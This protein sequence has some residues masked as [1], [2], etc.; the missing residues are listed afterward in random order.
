MV[1]RLVGR[2]AQISACALL[3]A[4]A[5]PALAAPV[6]YNLDYSGAGLPLWNP[7]DADP[8]F[9][10]VLAEVPVGP[11]IGPNS[12]VNIPPFGEFGF[13]ANFSAGVN[14][15][16][17]TKVADFHVGSTDIH[18][19]V[20]IDLDFPNRVGR[21][22]EFTITSSFTVDP[23]ANFAAVADNGILDIGARTGLFADLTLKACAF[24][25]FVDEKPVDINEPLGT[26]PLV[27]QTQNET[28]FQIDIPGF[29]K[30]TIAGSGIDIDPDNTDD[31]RPA[32]DPDF[33]FDLAVSTVTNFS[34][35][36]QAPKVEVD[37]S[38]DGNKLKGTGTDIF[39]DVDVNLTG[40]IPG[41]ALANFG[42]ID[43]GHGLQFGYDLF[44]GVLGTQLIGRQ[45]LEFDA[46]P[47]IMLDL[48]A[49][50]THVFTAGESITLTAPK[51]FGSF[52]ILPSFK[53]VNTFTNEIILAAT[54]DFV[55]TVGGLFLS[56][57][58]FVLIPPTDPVIIDPPSFCLIPN[59]FGGCI[60]RVNPPPFT[61]VPGFDGVSID[62]F[63]FDEQIFQQ[64][65]KD[66]LI[67]DFAGLNIGTCDVTDVCNSLP[68]FGADG[69]EASS[70]FLSQQSFDFDPIVGAGIRISVI[71]VPA[72]FLLL[73]SGLACLLFVGR[74]RV[75]T[76]RI[77]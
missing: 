39:T 59:P 26:L 30:P 65:F 44:S 17:E 36:V 2:S 3:F 43:I 77:R 28:E 52:D 67:K 7:S 46:A 49:L 64:S 1:Q 62:G 57:P 50:G 37:G 22:E 70:R 74:S 24:G 5:T 51:E 68:L 4:F 76:W 54:Q 19:P 47:E 66:E 12:V 35:K 20:R 73:I 56:L 21:G 40:F 15:G 29:G 42:P 9:A 23:A 14:I 27:R 41:A 60:K 53:L 72:T 38:L 58:D 31:S 71:P 32:N 18:Y 45:S 13:A 8:I 11:S 69:A 10:P 25:C 55:V 34:G 61:L 75:R 33:L 63:T 48:G 16:L 6:S